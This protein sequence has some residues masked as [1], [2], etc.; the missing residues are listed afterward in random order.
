MDRVFA[1]LEKDGHVVDLYHGR[2]P[3]KERAEVRK[4][5]EPG[6]ENEVKALVGHPQSGGR[7]LDLS[8]AGK[9]IWYSHTFNAI[10]RGQADERATAIGG[11]N[12]PVLDLVA[13]GVDVYVLDNVAKK[14]D[15]ADDLA[16][17][18]MK[19]VLKSLEI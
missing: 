1:R 4:R 13:P 18:G 7:G 6:A 19:Q 8:S 5:F 9:I 11:K 15:I 17:R 16:G 12:I 14:V 2:V 10:T 3:D